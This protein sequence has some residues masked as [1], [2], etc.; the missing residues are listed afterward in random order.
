MIS[1]KELWDWIRSLLVAVLLA[2]VIRVFFFEVFIV[3]G[4][5]M[6]P[7]LDD[8][9]RVVVS[10]S[11][12]HFSDPGIGD[13][14]IF[15]HEQGRPFIKRIVGTEGDII[16]I[17]DQ[18]VYVNNQPLVEPYLGVDITMFDY[19][20]VEV[21]PGYYFVLGDYRNN[22]MDSRD[23]RVG[24]IEKNDLKGRALLIFWPPWEARIISNKVDYN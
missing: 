3:E 18:I 15:D 6:Y 23:P 9:E 8:M 12:Y 17:K 21:P 5:S 19:G 13:I 22:S 10:K 4:K 20:P 16:Q 1:Q 7:T 24:F 11:V 2:I 14:V